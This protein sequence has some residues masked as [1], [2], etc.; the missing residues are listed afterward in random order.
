MAIE[1]WEAMERRHTERQGIVL[2]EKMRIMILF[3]LVPVKL[4][5][6]I[7][8]QTTKWDSYTALRDHLHSLQHLRTTGAAPM[9][10]NLEDQD[11]WQVLPEDE[12]ATED[13][14]IFRLERRN[15]KPFAVRTTPPQGGTNQRPTTSRATKPA[16]RITA[17]HAC[18]REGH[19]RRDCKSTKH[20]DGGP[21]RPP[22]PPRKGA[23]NVEEGGEPDQEVD[24]E[25]N[26][27]MIE[28]NA[29]SSVE[30]D[31]LS[32]ADE[33]Q[34]WNDWMQDAYLDP[35]SCAPCEKLSA[36]KLPTLKDL[37][38]WKDVCAICDRAGVY[39]TSI[40][41]QRPDQFI[42]PL[43]LP[44]QAGAGAIPSSERTP[45]T[46][47]PKAP[48]RTIA[49]ASCVPEPL[50][51]EVLEWSPPV[52]VM[53][54]SD[55]RSP[56][57]MV[58]A[59]GAVSVDHV[60]AVDHARPSQR[61]SSL[62]VNE[63]RPALPETP[64]KVWPFQRES[65]LLVNELRSVR[66]M[67]NNQQS[68]KEIVAASAAVSGADTVVSS[69]VRKM[70]AHVTSDPFMDSLDDDTSP[71]PDILELNSFEKT[72]EKR[73]NYDQIDITMDSGAGGSVADPKDFPG[74]VVTDSP[75]SLAGQVFV[76]PGGD[77]MPNQGQFVAPLRLDDGR[78]TQSIYQ[79]VPVRKPLMAVSA[80]NDKGN[81]VVFDG[82]GS[83]IVPGSNKGL[84]SQIRALIQKV[85]DKVPLHRKNGVF[86]MKAW[87]LKPGFT[88]QGM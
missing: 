50:E 41:K 10:Y 38:G 13:G 31:A 27:G 39:A 28:L 11:G 65:S 18:G 62:L 71:W 72:A 3:E 42:Q 83:Y 36:F 53:K 14:D 81:L 85:P 33:T 12:I 61:E 59:S 86:H 44:S 45:T 35:W 79:A 47:M 66:K 84:I 80:V 67:A 6:E 34:A 32:S 57:E 54:A 64:N 25:V 88:R 24:A 46:P 16:G 21:I 8:K 56:K 5:E 76:G 22:P 40:S 49:L 63:S 4:K 2:Q 23:N 1:S 15:G 87:Q 51:E 17:C 73:E 75:G 52:H 20:K 78:L 55:E 68:T 29:L 30:S 82:K 7:M 74:C 48:P 58:P 9:V 60:T 69:I 19:F 77:K 26:V 70:R 43:S 37:Y